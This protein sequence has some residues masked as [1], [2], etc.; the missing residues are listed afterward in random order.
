MMH[1]AVRR[2]RGL[3][4]PPGLLASIARG[5][6]LAKFSGARIGRYPIVLNGVRFHVKGDAVIGERFMALPQPPKPN[7]DV[8]RGAILR[9][10][11][12]FVLGG[13]GSIEAWHEIRIGNNVMFGAHCS[14]SDDNGHLSEPT[15]GSPYRGPTIIEDNVWL[16]RNVTVLSG[17]TVGA[18]SVIAAN[19][20]VAQNIPPNSF[21]SGSPARVRKSLEIP[22]GWNRRFGFAQDGNSRS[23]WERLHQAVTNPKDMALGFPQGHAQL[24]LWHRRRRDHE[25]FVTV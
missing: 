24:P 9:V 1:E 6:V 7:I 18:G 20:V 12:G 14:I 22:D 23:L 13:G 8:A 16:T 5:Y 17:V 10:G 2:C 15:S 4:D 25:G 3:L 19:S 11:N 21:A